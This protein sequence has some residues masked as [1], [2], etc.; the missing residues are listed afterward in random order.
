MN[1][2]PLLSQL[3]VLLIVTLAFTSET[4]LGFGSTII[5]VALGS[6]FLPLDVLLAAFVPVNVLL[7]V[8]LVRSRLTSLIVSVSLPLLPV[9]VPFATRS[10]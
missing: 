5:A 3:A 8:V 10:A 7:S 9:T 2:T 4:A 1:D 6:F